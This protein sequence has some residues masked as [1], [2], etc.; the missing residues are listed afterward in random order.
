MRTYWTAHGLA[1]LGHEVEVTTNALE[2]EP[3]FRLFMRDEDW[4]RCEG[5]YD[6]GR[7]RVHWTD[8][9]DRAQFHLPMASPF[10]SKLA[11][12]A[13]RLH[14]ERPFDVIFS[15]YL[16]PYGVAGYLA[17]QMTGAPHVVRM[18][19][20]DSGRLWH[21]P[22][23]EPLYDHVL[24]SAAAVIAAGVVAERA[25]ARGVDP[26]R[27]AAADSVAVPEDLFAP[28]GPVLDLAALRAEVATD[29]A[30]ADLLWG[31]F[32]GDRPYLGIYGKLG[33]RK[34]SFALLEA[35]AQLKRAG[36]DVGLVALAHGRVE[37]EHQFRSE[38]ERLDLE[39]RVLQVPFL[40]HWRVPEFLRGCLAVCCLEQD[41]PIAHHIPIV[42]LEVLLCGKCLIGST[43]VIRKL[44]DY[45]RLPDGY[46]CVAIE[47][48][49]DVDQ[50]SARLAAIVRDP[51]PAAAMGARGHAF[52][53]ALQQEGDF[54]HSLERILAT[55]AARESLDEGPVAAEAVRDNELPRFPFARR[56][57]AALGVTDDGPIELMGARDV[58]GELE[59]R[60]G[61]GQSSLAPLAAA[62][63]VEIAVAAVE[64]EPA[65]DDTDDPLFRLCLGRWALAEEDLPRLVPVRDPALRLLVFAEDIALLSN[66]GDAAELPAQLM[67]GPSFLAAFAGGIRE[68]LLVDRATARILE[69]SDGTRTVA[70]LAAQLR[71][72]EGFGDREDDLAWI[73]ALFLEGLVRLCQPEAESR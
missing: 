17:A 37:I 68:P 29:P 3:P 73:E 28:L 21:H 24:R 9:V 36:L 41:F 23:L 64:S 52:A 1:R 15:H 8:P 49:S 65:P 22:Q 6:P 67:P 7:V 63:R 13:A 43:E 4:Q 18:A 30:W 50:L 60:V 12:I 10:V 55:V 42:A 25:M 11:G 26:A 33:A 27:I 61:G 20:S 66:A 38:V 34:G 58:L 71:A 59:Q 69:L 57:L 44:P 5:D 48:V 32:A 39:D 72:E 45:T 70:T 19:G 51:V 62:L 16:E 53:R 2:A 14:A 54:P 40:P 56:A 35:L 46:G 31:G 47:D